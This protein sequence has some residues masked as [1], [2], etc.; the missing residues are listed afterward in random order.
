M[1]ENHELTQAQELFRRGSTTYYARR[2]LTAKAILGAIRKTPGMTKAEIFAEINTESGHGGFEV[3]TR[4]KMA[5][6]TGSPARWFAN[7]TN[8]KP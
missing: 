1:K 8:P 3:L 7:N 4:N 2:T 5:Y 6:S